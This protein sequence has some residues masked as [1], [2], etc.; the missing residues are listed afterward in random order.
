[1][2]L[3]ELSAN[4]QVFANPERSEGVPVRAKGRM[5]RSENT[6]IYDVGFFAPMLINGYETG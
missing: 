5:P 3:S 1:M 6:V 2:W 4:V